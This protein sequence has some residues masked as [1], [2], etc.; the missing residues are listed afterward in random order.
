VSSASKEQ[1]NSDR[2]AT[3]PVRAAGFGEKAIEMGLLACAGLSILTTIGVLGVLLFETASF[4]G[5]V[6]F[7]QFLLDTQWTPLFANKHFG[8]WPLISG[9]LLTSFVAIVVALPLGLLAAIYLS[10]YAGHRARAIIKP[11]L[12]L[13]AGV[14]TIVYGY[15][16]LVFLTPI[17]QL[18]VPDLQGFNALSPGLI[19][20]IM[21]MPM[22]SSLSEDA[23][24][25]VPNALREG[26]YG[27]GASKLSTIFRVIVPAAKSGVVAAVTLAVSRAIGETM[28]VTIAGGAQPNL[29]FDPRGAV[30]T[31]TAF[32]ISVSK[33]DTPTGSIEYQTIFAVGTTLFLMTFVMNLIAQ[34]LL[35][36]ARSRGF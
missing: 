3:R 23:L 21:I 11:T 4:F 27:L 16:A 33:G 18:F 12:E 34:R 14:P 20:G 28:I 30:E 5:Q 31:M 13:L 8:I 10:E 32:I 24:H 26:A 17:L 29:T 2:Q 9:T 19:M 6:S 1:G 35:R 36:K 15:F 22:I 7:S 25:A